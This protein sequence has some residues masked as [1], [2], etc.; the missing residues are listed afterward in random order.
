MT[1]KKKKRNIY[2]TATALISGKVFSTVIAFVIILLQSRYLGPEVI[3]FVDQFAIPIGYMWILSLGL[4]S[5]L[6]RELPYYL[7]KGEKD[8][9]MKMTQTVESFSVVIGTLCAVAFLVLSIRYLLIKEYL[10]AF[11]WGIQIFVAF[12]TIYASFLLTTFRTAD[13]FIEISKSHFISGISIIF[14]FPLIFVNPYIGLIL[15]NRVPT[16][17]SYIYLFFKRPFKLKFNFSFKLFKELFKFGFPISIIAYI[18]SALWLAVQRTIILQFGDV[19]LLGIYGFVYRIITSLLLVAYSLTDI[20][21]PR[22]AARYARFDKDIGKTIKSVML[23]IIASFG[24]SIVLCV[25]GMF[26]GPILI[27]SILPKYIVVIPAINFALM[28]LPVIA[29]NA[30]KYIF[31]VTK[32]LLFNLM[33][34]LP[35]FI[36]A[37]ALQYFFAMSE[38]NVFYL[39]L[40]YLLGQVFNFII[41]VILIFALIKKEKTE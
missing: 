37:I 5:A 2:Q 23:P 26:T 33:S 39:F 40:P 17:L 1:K 30:L 8:K 13:E 14:L 21:R 29:L 36:L 19:E 10:L 34:I 18:D 16:F 35:G 28:L 6:S 20:V 24:L 38:N 41:T 12:F 7:E 11:G 25:V 3:G 31:V 9:A 27:E 4:P 22:M 32:K 15:K